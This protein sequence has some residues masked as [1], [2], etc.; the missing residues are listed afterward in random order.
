MGGHEATLRTAHTKGGDHMVTRTIKA[1]LA[2][3]AT[4]A[5]AAALLSAPAYAADTGLFGSQGATYDGVFRQSLA[6][7]GLEATGQSAPTSAVEWLLDQ[8]CA[9]GSFQSYR[10]DTSK[11]CGKSDPVNFSGP[12]TDATGLAAA[13]LQLAGEQAAARRA[14]AWLLRTQNDDAGFAS[15]VGGESNANSTAMALVGLQTVRP[16]GS[17]SDVRSAKQFLGTL[18][19]R[20]SS[21]G[22]LPFTRGNPAN[23]LASSQAFMGLAGALPVETDA[24]LGANPGCRKRNTVSNVGSFLATAI[25]ENGAI[26]SDFGSGPDYSSTGWA[27]L[28]FVAE[29]IGADAVREG[30]QTL[31]ANA[32]EYALKDGEA[33]P[34]A[35][36]LLLLVAEATDSSA[37]DFGGV[38]LI[39]TLRQS[40]Q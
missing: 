24:D 14:A 34:A 26:P 29:G 15:Y 13:A 5:L 2:T 31:K 39:S 40:I 1:A 28:G 25:G 10:A 20:C 3:T 9:D 32:E 11:R 35:I 7:A 38:N 12:N 17:S 18:K 4:A 8:Q 36:G 23:G 16:V 19:L 6:I 27:I 37:T 22:G 21:G 30:L 33:V